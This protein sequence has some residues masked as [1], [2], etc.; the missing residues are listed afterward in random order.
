M[1]IQRYDQTVKIWASTNDTYRWANRSGESWPC[2][3]L[4]GNRLFAEFDKGHLV[5][6]AINGKDGVDIDATE[7]NAFTQ[8]ILNGDFK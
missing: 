5:D 4:S 3:Q 7:F 2:S 1:R 6:Y 8:D